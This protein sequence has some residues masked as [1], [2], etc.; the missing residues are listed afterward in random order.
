MK[1]D[2]IIV[3]VLSLLIGFLYSMGKKLTSPASEEV[4]EEQMPSRELAEADCPQEFLDYI[5]KIGMEIEGGENDEK[6]SAGGA[7]PDGRFGFGFVRKITEKRS[8]AQTFTIDPALWF[9]DAPDAPNGFYIRNETHNTRDHVIS[10]DANAY[11]VTT[12]SGEE[13]TP[14]MCSLRM[15]TAGEYI[16]RVEKQLATFPD[17]LLPIYYDLDADGNITRIVEQYVP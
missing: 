4:L 11:I 17:S 3:V 16:T 15:V 10:P 14:G 2:I 7:E 1:K 6:L 5:S 13:P 12:Y 8:A 9:S